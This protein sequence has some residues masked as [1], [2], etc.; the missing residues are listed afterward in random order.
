MWCT[1]KK[2]AISRHI[3]GSKTFS[4]C[5]AY[6]NAVYQASF[7]DEAAE[8]M[9]DEYNRPFSG[10]LKLEATSGIEG[11]TERMTAYR[12]VGDELACQMLRVIMYLVLRSSV[13][14]YTNRC[15]VPVCQDANS[16]LFKGLR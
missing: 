10:F 13:G 9:A 5:M 6:R 1:E 16:L 11:N 7:H 2:N 4:M 8:G 15:I 3:D 14:K 12:S